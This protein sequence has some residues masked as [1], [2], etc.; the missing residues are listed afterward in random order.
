MRRS[1]FVALL[2]FGMAWSIAAGLWAAYVVFHLPPLFVASAA[3]IMGIGS[4][5]VAAA[6]Y[7]RFVAYNYSSGNSMERSATAEL[8]EARDLKR[9]LYVIYHAMV[10]CLVGA[11]AWQTDDYVTTVIAFVIGAAIVV[12]AIR[13]YRASLTV[14]S[15]EE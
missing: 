11:Y 10:P 12:W 3:L 7:R 4:V 1:L 14:V 2:V 6:V 5:A 8:K 9:L 15:K 13:R